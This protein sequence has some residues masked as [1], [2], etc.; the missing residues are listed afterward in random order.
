MQKEAKNSRRFY[1]SRKSKFR[2]CKFDFEI[3]SQ[4]TNYKL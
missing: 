3:N 1:I 2:L 4:K